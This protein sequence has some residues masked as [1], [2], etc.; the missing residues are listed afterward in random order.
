MESTGRIYD[1][2]VECFGGESVFRDIDSIPLGIPFP[3]LLHQTLARTSAVLVI[4]GPSWL[5]IENPSGKPR[6][7]DP[8]DYVRVEVEMALHHGIP[9]IPVTVAHA[10]LP[11]MTDLPE[12]LGALALRNGYFV[13]PDPDFHR[14][15]DQL[16][17]KIGQ[18]FHLSATGVRKSQQLE[19]ELRDLKAKHSELRTELVERIRTLSEGERKRQA[20][21]R[22]TPYWPLFVAFGLIS[23]CYSIDFRPRTLPLVIIAVLLAVVYTYYYVVET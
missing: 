2:L 22:K 13:R 23:V 20:V 19:L 15:M 9:V 8:D 14:D 7:D 6:L 5:T 1:R 10:K 16:C 11:E 17:E 21:H 4:I 3:E 18:L 12:S